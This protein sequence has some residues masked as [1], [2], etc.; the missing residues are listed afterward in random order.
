MIVNLDELYKYKLD[1]ARQ[2]IKDQIFPRFKTSRATGEIWMV[3]AKGY[4]ELFWSY[5]ME[6]DGIPDPLVED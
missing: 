1:Q 4:K 5:S 6:I 3:D 2:M